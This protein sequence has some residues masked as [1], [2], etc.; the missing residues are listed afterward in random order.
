[1]EEEEEQPRIKKGLNNFSWIRSPFKGMSK[2]QLDAYGLLSALF[3]CMSYRFLCARGLFASVRQ[4]GIHGVVDA[5]GFLQALTELRIT[6]KYDSEVSVQM[7]IDTVDPLSDGELDIAEL[8]KAVDQVQRDRVRRSGGKPINA[9]SLGEEAR[10]LSGRTALTAGELDEVIGQESDETRRSFGVAAFT[11]SLLFCGLVHM[12]AH[13]STR[14]ASKVGVPGGVCC[15]WLLAFLRNRFDLL[16][17]ANAEAAAS[18]MPSPSSVSDLPPPLA[19]PR[20]QRPLSDNSDTSASRASSRSSRN[21]SPERG[22]SKDSAGTPPKEPVRPA[23]M[24]R[25]AGRSTAGPASPDVQFN[26]AATRRPKKKP[27]KER[28]QYSTFPEGGKGKGKDAEANDKQHDEKNVMPPENGEY[29]SSVNW[30]LEETPDLFDRYDDAE[31][32]RETDVFVGGHATARN[33]RALCGFCGVRRNHR[34]MGVAYCH[35]CSGVDECPLS[36]SMLYA[37]FKRKGLEWRRWLLANEAAKEGSEDQDEESG[38]GS[39][40]AQ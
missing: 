40:N 30:I 13:G 6:H 3:D 34:G 19:K 27:K 18:R 22:Y 8:E 21:E 25:S 9:V 10:H 33:S 24:S 5:K 1:M 12:H 17:K 31:E 4:G 11:E 29:K 38:S 35:V 14:S 2:A 26:L 39:A 36:E 23:D 7:F 32:G 20:K 15:L 37:V 16:C 28:G